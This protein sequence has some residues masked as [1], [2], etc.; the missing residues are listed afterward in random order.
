MLYILKGLV[1]LHTEA[2]DTLWQRS[3]HTS[4][5]LLERS[6]LSCIVHP[7]PHQNKTLWNSWTQYSSFIFLNNQVEEILHVSCSWRQTIHLIAIY[8]NT[9]VVQGCHRVYGHK[10]RLQSCPHCCLVTKHQFKS[11]SNKMHLVVDWFNASLCF[12]ASVLQ[13]STMDS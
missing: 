12:S 7:P 3:L 4:L 9:T 2:T 10:I 13:F 5:K 8:S 11:H 6:Q 1:S